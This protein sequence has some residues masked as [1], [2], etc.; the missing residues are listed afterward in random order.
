M[1]DRKRQIAVRFD[2]AAASYDAAARVQATTAGALADCIG[3]LDL[4]P[5]PRILEVGCGTGNLTAAMQGSPMQGI[6]MQGILGASQYLAT[7]IAPGM[8]AACRR[9]QSG[10]VAFAVMDAERPA[11]AA[12]SM[13]LIC[14]NLAMQ[15]FDDLP[16]ALA[17]L[18]ALL[19]PG[20]YL[21]FS[22]LGQETFCEWRA[23]HRELGLSAGVPRY[24]TLA[25]LGAMRPPG[26][27]A[28]RADQCLMI[29]THATAIAFLQSLKRIGADLSAQTAKPL[30][31]GAL[32]RVIRRIDAAAVKASY[33]VLT[34]ILRRS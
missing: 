32:R 2:R 20:G 26:F 8:I 33:H 7:D 14:A 29:E 24:P 6:P 4:P 5:F 9:R 30:S 16:R 21:A 12:D 23:A 18:G 15:W 25:E 31:A 17:G 10:S 13:D 11:I 3:G 27:E 28:V 22:T 19:R 34:L 1:T